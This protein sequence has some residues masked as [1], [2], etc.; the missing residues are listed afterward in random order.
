[1]TKKL[2]DQNAVNKF[3]KKFVDIIQKKN[4]SLG[5]MYSSDETGLK[6]LLHAFIGKT[7]KPKIL[8]FKDI[9]AIE[10]VN[11]GYSFP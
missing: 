1:M 2:A 9:N 8:I 10:T 7:A 5:Q 4:L 3:S 11:Q 6:L